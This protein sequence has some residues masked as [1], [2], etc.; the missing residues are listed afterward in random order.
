MLSSLTDASKIVLIDFS[1]SSRIMPGPPNKY[2]PLKGLTYVVGTPD[3]ASLNAHDGIAACLTLVYKRRLGSLKIIDLG[4]RDDLESLAYTTFFLLRG[5]LP[6]ITSDFR[7]EPMKNSMRRIHASKT[8]ASGDKLGAG[9]P[10]EFGHLLDY[11]RRL[12]YS[13]L[14]E[15]AELE[16]RFTDLNTWLGGKDPEAPLDWSPVEISI[17]EEHT[18]LEITHSEDE[19]ESDQESDGENREEIYADSYFGWDISDWDMRYP[20]DPSLTLPIEQA[21]LAD[22][23]IAQ[24]IEVTE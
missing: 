16:S 18:N 20:R 14:P 9:F 24:I 8:A 10:A 13:Q 5:D 21:E 12:E 6:W 17:S 7:R 3:W 23:S 19:A 1:I 15:Y 22:G 2:D 11:S 4:P